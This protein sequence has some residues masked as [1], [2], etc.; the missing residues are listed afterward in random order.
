MNILI[1]VI[2]APMVFLSLGYFDI[3]LVSLVVFFLSIIWFVIAF[4]KDKKD[5]LYPSLYI[6][7]AGFTFFLEEF[8]LLK[9][10]PLLISIVITSLILISYIN[11]NSIILYFAKR[12]S[13]NEI[14]E[15]EQVYIHNS[16]LFWVGIASTNIL[17]HSLIFIS[18]NIEFWVYY[19]SFG[20][21]F[22]FIFGG[23][24]Q[25]LHRKYI[26]LKEK[27]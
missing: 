23:V 16:T 19:S 20:W 21:Y 4:Q 25:F 9:A 3:G 14:S 5:A 15:K 8:L 18:E 2:Y 1:S 27:T 11:K 12:F 24:V 6:V 17:C 10:I 13:T 22:V 7:I 26:F